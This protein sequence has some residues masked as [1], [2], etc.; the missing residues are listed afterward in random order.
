MNAFWHSP[1][2]IQPNQRQ[3]RFLAFVGFGFLTEP[4]LNRVVRNRSYRV[5]AKLR[6]SRLY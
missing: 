1:Y 2:G 5:E 6:K 3:M 4:D